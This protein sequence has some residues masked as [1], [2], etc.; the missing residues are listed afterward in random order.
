MIVRVRWGMCWEESMLGRSGWRL[1]GLRAKGRGG[2]AKGGL[3]VCEWSVAGDR[4]VER[5]E[6][7]RKSEKECWRGY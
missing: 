1:R 4:G 3:S 2:E 6:A 5:V 7:S